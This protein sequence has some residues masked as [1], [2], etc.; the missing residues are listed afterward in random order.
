MENKVQLI[1]YA[2]RFGEKDISSFHEFLKKE[3]KGKVEGVHLLPFFYPIDGADAGYDP[4][5]NRVVDHRIGDWD[6]VRKL[7][8]DFPTTVDL[9]I[10]H[11]SD[12]SSEFQDVL[13]KGSASDYYELFLTKEKVFDGLANEEDV[14]KIYRPR[15][16]RP[17]SLRQ[18]ESGEKVEFWTT[19]SH[20]QIDIDV[21]SSKGKQ[22]INSVL[23]VFSENGIKT[24]RLDAV[25]YSIKKAGTS[26]F[27]IPETYIFIQEVV[28]K[29]HQHGIEVLVEVHAH[30]KEQ[31]KISEHTDYVYDFALP[32]LVLHS[33]FS[34]DFSRLKHWLSISPRNCITVL[35]THDGIG[36]MDAAPS[37]GE[38]GLLTNEELNELV[39]T[40]HNNSKGESKKATGAA[41]SNLDL[42]QVNCTYYDALGKNDLKYIMARAIQFFVPGVPQVYYGG[43]IAHENDMQLLEHTNIGRD[44]NRP[45]LS[46]DCIKQKIEQPVVKNL[47]ELMELRNSHP[48]FQGSFTLH[49]TDESLLKIRWEKDQYYS[50]L[51]VDLE[52]GKMEIE[53]GENDTNEKLRYE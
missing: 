24:I 5:D 39:E 50:E 7:S 12:K 46:Y 18:L 34:S 2:N 48:S 38:A 20:K 8:G 4:H 41:A 37:D 32:P 1:S 47:L 53:F 21:H 15:P 31:I 3:L 35:D 33:L 9:I 44:I 27:M 26:C 51:L 28:Q 14:N 29:A 30:H 16:N 40:I 42:Y 13:K 19:F 11:I 10:N 6:A 43:L 17:F 23:E 25:G 45:H 22:Y 36:V 49:N 52:N